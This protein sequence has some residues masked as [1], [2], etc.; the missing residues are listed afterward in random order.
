MFGIDRILE[1][2]NRTENGD[3]QEYFIEMGIEVNAFMQ[4]APQFDDLT[5]LGIKIIDIPERESDGKNPNEEE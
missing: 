3:V 1:V 5:M 2:L 4:D